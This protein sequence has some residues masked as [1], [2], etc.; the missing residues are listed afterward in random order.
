M[1][2][3]RGLSFKSGKTN[4][5]ADSFDPN[6]GVLNAGS[7]SASNNSDN[8]SKYAEIIGQATTGDMDYRRVGP[9]ALDWNHATEDR[10]NPYLATTKS[11]YEPPSTAGATSKADEDATRVYLQH[12]VR[13]ADPWPFGSL[14]DVFLVPCEVHD[15]GKDKD[16]NPIR[17][18]MIGIDKAEFYSN[19]VMHGA[20]A[21]L[22]PQEEPPPYSIEARV[23]MYYHRPS[24]RWRWKTW[25]IP[26]RAPKPESPGAPTDPPPPPPFP[27]P[28]PGTQPTGHGRP[29][30]SGGG[31]PSGGGGGSDPTD[32]PGGP[33]ENPSSVN[34]LPGQ[35][36][37]LPLPGG[38]EYAPP[39]GFYGVF[40]PSRNDGTVEMQQAMGG[41]DPNVFSGLYGNR[42]TRSARG[43]FGTPLYVSGVEY[44]PTR[45]KRGWRGTRLIDDPGELDTATVDWTDNTNSSFTQTQYDDIHETTERKE[46]MDAINVLDAKATD[47]DTRARSSIMDC[48][49]V[50]VLAGNTTVSTA[51][52]Y[53]VS[54]DAPKAVATAMTSGFNV[55]VESV[56]GSD[57]TT[58]TADVRISD[59]APVGGVECSIIWQYAVAAGTDVSA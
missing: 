27:N 26:G 35:T 31:T 57:G 32:L 5:N 9:A 22:G 20:L 10:W 30:P 25:L 4:A 42:V 6:T 8:R 28:N 51:T 2:G 40:T 37:E 53:A 44:L 15:G 49:T 33:V 29:R 46:L 11:T 41:S 24:H 39:G 52:T 45:P 3:I 23:E 55:N 43:W 56:S 38:E 47:L 36:G 21:H 48:T 14:N 12:R 54:G 59:A 17:R 7:A 16:D 19:D 34:P 58:Y 18:L 50:T 1:P 13:D